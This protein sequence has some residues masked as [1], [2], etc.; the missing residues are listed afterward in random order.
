MQGEIVSCFLGPCS[1]YVAAHFWNSTTQADIQDEVLYQG[2][3]EN[4]TPRVLCVDFKDAVDTQYEW[5]LGEAPID[6]PVFE[7][8]WSP[9]S[10]M[11]VDF[12]DV[13]D[14]TEMDRDEYSDGEWEGQKKRK[15]EPEANDSSEEEKQVDLVQKKPR[16]GLKP[17]WQ[18]IVP[19][20]HDESLQLVSERS[21]SNSAGLGSYRLYPAGT[22]KDLFEVETYMDA[23]RR[24]VEGCDKL[25]GYNMTCDALSAFGG[26][27]RQLAEEIRDDFG[28]R[29]LYLTA[30]HDVPRFTRTHRN[31]Q[32]IVRRLNNGFSTIEL[33]NAVD[34]YTPI[35][36]ADWT[37]PQEP[38]PFPL[39]NFDPRNDVVATTAVIAA[40]LDTMLL[41]MRQSSDEAGSYSLRDLC[42]VV[43]VYNAMRVASMF[44]AF[45]FPLPTGST[46]IVGAL[47][48][49]PLF[50]PAFLPLSHSVPD[51]I[52]PQAVGQAVVFRGYGDLPVNPPPPKDRFAARAAASNLV[53]DAQE[54]M[55]HFCRA[56]PAMQCMY[57]AVSRAYPLSA[58]F[59]TGI[60]SSSLDPNG[61]IDPLR[62]E[63]ASPQLP[64]PE[65][66]VPMEGN[67]SASAEASGPPPVTQLP[68]A[69]HLATV[70]AIHTSLRKLADDFRKLPFS[71]IQS[72]GRVQDEFKE[73][74]DAL[75]SLADEY[76]DGA[77]YSDSEDISD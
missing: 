37:L 35:N 18:Y 50:S 13:E 34:V 33:S 55:E 32:E 29:P 5:R 49:S 53:A 22:D 31:K 9:P 10:A 69:A 72:Y 16:D 40:S 75:L 24:F 58:A 28:P 7:L 14:E 39:L 63:P 67:A 74:G 56:S 73:N 62:P 65:D 25:Q 76:A 20:L 38:M 45:P 48:A 8:A 19:A 17:G 26:L 21:E 54:A 46:S 57:S 68:M 27:T 41:P 30:V 77:C 43:R 3:P 36:I 61:R 11:M 15:T 64:E 60:L 59:P 47:S 71:F 66:D 44:T 23:L 1:N 42:G 6:V 52:N 12:S 4:R 2:R 51:C 70:P